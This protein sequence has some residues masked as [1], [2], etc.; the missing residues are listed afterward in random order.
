MI[1]GRVKFRNPNALNARAECNRKGSQDILDASK[2]VGVDIIC[3]K[4][5]ESPCR[6]IKVENKPPAQC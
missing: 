2:E 1:S 6:I 4:W 3:E 5:N